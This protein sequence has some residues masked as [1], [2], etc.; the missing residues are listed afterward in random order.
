MREKLKEVYGTASNSDDGAVR[1]AAREML[2]TF[3]DR[4]V[5]GFESAVNRMSDACDPYR[6]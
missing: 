4:D 6:G 1:S 2:A 5:S 3:T